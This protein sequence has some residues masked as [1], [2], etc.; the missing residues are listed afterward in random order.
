MNR[1]IDRLVLDAGFE[2]LDFKKFYM[3]GPKV[4]TY[5]YG[6]AASPL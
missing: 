2:I 5:M 6:G 4:L 3:E 1:E